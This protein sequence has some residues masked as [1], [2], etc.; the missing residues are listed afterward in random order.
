MGRQTRRKGAEGDMCSSQAYCCRHEEL[1]DTVR[2]RLYLQPRY[3][4]VARHGALAG[5]G[6]N[7]RAWRALPLPP[8]GNTTHANTMPSRSWNLLHT[9]RRYR[10][11]RWYKRLPACALRGAGAGGRARACLLRTASYRGLCLPAHHRYQAGELRRCC[12]QTGLNIACC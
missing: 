7:A 2:R 10:D 3:I 9:V 1:G 11:W 8:A 6:G 4:C 12:W 5:R